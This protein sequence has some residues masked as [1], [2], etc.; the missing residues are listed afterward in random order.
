MKLFLSFLLFSF[1]QILCNTPSPT[2]TTS[3]SS[4]QSV[5][6]SP[7]L[8]G[9]NFVAPPR[10]F[11][12]NPM[13]EVQ[14]INADWIAIIPYGF[15]L[16]KENK[17]HYNEGKKGQQWWG[18]CPQG[19]RRT[20]QLA[21]EAHLNTMLKPQIYMPQ[22]WTGALDFEQESDWIAWEESYEKFILLMAQL[23]E[24]EHCTIFCMGTEF[25]IAAVKRETF[26]RNLILKIKKVYSG[27]ITYAA[28]WDEYTNVPFW[29]A[30]D[31]TGVNAYFPLLQEATPSVEQLQK[32]WQKPLS[33]LRAFYKKTKKPIL[34][35]EY[36]YLSVD[37][38]A[39]QGWEI[40]KRIDET[41]INEQAQANAL[42]A[43][44]QTFWNEPYWAGGFLWKWFPN[45]QGHEGYPEKDYTPQ[46]KK[47]AGVVK[48]WYGK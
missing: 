44:Y 25:K 12:K 24:E 16:P 14:A 40:E 19:V 33:D 43:L 45:M 36:G 48:E 31:Y 46:G 21:H 47:A 35:T 23:A 39:Y 34:F 2:T 38:C 3:S 1:L 5:G 28:N 18:E 26:W 6:M 42:A 29:D 7:K 37:G 22:S 30:L 10:E 32:A 15:T 17:V 27:K 8:K 9:L 11:P 41:A 13:P 20:M 4:T